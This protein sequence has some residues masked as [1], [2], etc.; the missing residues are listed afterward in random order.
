MS[1][2]SVSVSANDIISIATKN[3]LVKKLILLNYV[4]TFKKD[5]IITLKSRFCKDLLLVGATMTLVFQNRSF[6]SEC[7]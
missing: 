5:L 3:L 7:V 1:E 6:V 4:N 2:V